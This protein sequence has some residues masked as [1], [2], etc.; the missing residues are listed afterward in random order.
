M[1]IYRDLLTNDEVLCDAYRLGSEDEDFLIT[2]QGKMTSVKVGGGI[3]ADLIGGNP[4][5]EEGAEEEVGDMS[6]T[7][8]G[9]DIVMAQ[10]LEDRSDYFISKKVLQGYLKKWAKN[11]A[12]GLKEEKEK[13]ECFKK[14]CATK[15]KAF[16][17]KWTSDVTVYTGANF[18]PEECKA[19]VL[20]GVWNED[21]MGM[22]L[23]AIRDGLIEEKF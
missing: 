12:D 10:N 18:D 23:Y 1:I 13:C 2:C 4:S 19:S 22:T 20:I 3:S 6:E 11:I 21:G 16:T 8:S 7:K 5:Q 9:I 17:D 14:N 15:L